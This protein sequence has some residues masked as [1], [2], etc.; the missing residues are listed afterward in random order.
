MRILHDAFRSSTFVLSLALFFGLVSVASADEPLVLFE[1]SFDCSMDGTDAHGVVKPLSVEGKAAY[2]QGRTAQ[3]LVCGGDG[4]LVKFPV[5]GHILASQ[6]TIEMW[7]RA[8]DWP[9]EE[10]A[11]HIFFETEG[12]GRITLYKFWTG[13]ALILS[14]KNY[15]DFSCAKWEDCTPI[16]D[17]KWH[18]LAGTWD[19]SRLAFY[20]DGQ[21]KMSV[22]KPI[23]P[24]ALGE[25]FTVGDAPWTKPHTSHT[26]IQNVKVY[27]VALP[28]DQVARL[29]QGRPVTFSNEARL[30]IEPRPAKGEWRVSL[31]ASGPLGQS[32]TGSTAV[33][34]VISGGKAVVSQKI[35]SFKEGIGVAVLPIAKIPVGDVLVKARVLDA[36]GKELASPQLPFKRPEDAPWAGNKIGMDDRV[37]APYTPM[38]VADGNAVE[39]WGR[40]YV[41]G[42]TG[43][44][45][46][47]ETA[48]QP[49]L[50]A[51]VN[52]SVT[53]AQGDVAF[54][55]VSE[56]IV[57]SSATRV[58]AVGSAESAAVTL[59]METTIEY[60]GMLWTD[61]TLTPTAPTTLTGVTIRVPVRS[62]NALYVHH[63]N[64]HWQDDGA[65]NLPADGYQSLVFQPLMWLGDNERGLA[66]FTES[67]Q[68][69]S[70]APGQPMYRIVRTGDAA[71]MQIYI[72]NRSTLIKTP[73]KFSFGLQATPVQPRPAN[74][75]SWRMGGAY[76][77]MDDLGM[78]NIQIVWAYHMIAYG[79][80]QPKDPAKFRA[81]VAD[82]H[83][84]NIRVV[85]YV[86]LN[87]FSEG[88]PEFAYYSPDWIDRS[89]NVSGGDVGEMGHTTY[90]ACPGSAAW[91]DFVSWKIAKFVEE[92]Q[93]DGLYV[94]CWMPFQ[95]CDED[96]GGSWR[97]EFGGLH[98]VY[99]VRAYRE[100]LRR[101]RE[102][103][104]DRRPNVHIMAHMSQCIVI[105][106]LS[107]A[108]SMLD[109]EQYQGP[110]CPKD[111]YLNVIPLDK[112]RAEHMG[113]QWG[114]VPFF[115]CEFLPADR[116]DLAVGRLMGLLLAHDITPSPLW[117]KSSV[118]F[119]AWKTLDKFGAVDADFL[120]YWTPNGVTTD[121]KDFI[122]SVYKKPGKALLVVVNSGNADGQVSIKVDA[123]QLG[124]AANASAKDAYDDSPVP[125][126]EQSFKLSIPRHGHKLLVL[127]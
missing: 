125:V 43:L 71:E 90:G 123:K 58:K 8:P 52:I 103:L 14:G 6:G 101:V 56:K 5:A 73:L 122:A 120:P 25:S 4:A 19:H 37:L 115:L 98:T 118:V 49:V 67:N 10:Q 53:T 93:V 105:P 97:D 113:R 72:V 55:K 11:Y 65:G 99:Q 110:L 17:G 38:H 116:T 83:A 92:Y 26:L 13:G 20:V 1:A 69:W 81:M 66:W 34:E 126:A 80:P 18:H 54:Q 63:A 51:P 33:V 87:Y 75:R 78:G 50:A 88:A 24:D 100:I 102:L 114:L 91:R 57:S 121:N 89:R 61:V 21:L 35:E 7:M 46:Q 27:R 39:C 2:D 74:A 32:A 47:I 124:L 30:D 104:Q 45:T 59:S 64:G 84:K 48:G 15:G 9:K 109:G 85:P 70:N 112:W 111:D 94:D 86:N 41:L 44:P 119:N 95:T 29:A 117:C 16:A 3:A 40:K 106:T 42:G 96:Y 60:D 23:L 82:L 76:D 79:Y 107:F 108:D 127:Q 36:A 31:D 22:D 77:N 68:T 12:P 62:A 28:A